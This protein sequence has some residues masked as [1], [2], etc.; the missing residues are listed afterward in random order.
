MNINT[1]MYID[2]SSIVG[3]TFTSTSD[4]INEF[5]C[6]GY[7]QNETFLVVGTSFDSANNRSIVRTF[8]F[9]D[10]KFKGQLSPSGQKT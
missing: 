6:I 10:V 2:P 3:K 5:T 1:T 8:K 4:P 9:S 7:G